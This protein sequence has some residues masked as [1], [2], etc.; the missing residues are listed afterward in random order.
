MF[1]MC[2]CVFYVV[3]MSV[4][5]VTVAHTQN[6]VPRWAERDSVGGMHMLSFVLDLRN[7]CSMHK[8]LKTNKFSLSNVEISS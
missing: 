1:E 6:C 7:M 8:Q 4:Q 2:K 5:Y 3:T